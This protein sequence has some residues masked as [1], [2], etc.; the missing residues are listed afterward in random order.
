[1]IMAGPLIRIMVLFQITQ[2]N[3][4]NVNQEAF[5]LL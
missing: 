1:M 2:M 3:K 5:G 4:E